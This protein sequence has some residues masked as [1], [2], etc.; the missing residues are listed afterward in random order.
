MSEIKFSVRD[1]F[2]ANV[3]FE[4]QVEYFGYSYLIIYGKHINGYFCAIPNH[5]ICCEM[6]D[7]NDTFYNS[8]R[9]MHAEIPEQTA[10][11]IAEAIKELS[12]I[13]KTA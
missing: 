4:A 2:N 13:N 9:L 10:D 8:E 11:N 1:I 6:S 5:G 12:I 3:M 7:P